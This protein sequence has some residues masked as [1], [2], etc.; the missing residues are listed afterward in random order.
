MKD[1]YDVLVIGAG[2]GGYVA[3]IRAAQLGKSVGVVEKR[4][5][6]GGTCLNIGCIPSKALLDSSE[7]YSRISNESRE[8]GI[9]VSDVSVDLPVMHGR[10]QAVVDRLTGG[11]AALI[12]AR[13]IDVIPGMATLSGNG[14]VEVSFSGA[15]TTIKATH[16]IIAT[17]SE[18][19]ELP[20][21]PFDGKSIVSSTEAL[22][23][24]AVPKELV[25]GGAGAIGLE[26][27]SVW[28]R[29]GSNV[30]VVEIMEEILP[31]WDA[32]LA[33]T[34]RRELK[35]QGFTF[36]LGHKVTGATPGKGRAKTTVAVETNKG[37][38]IDLKA[39]KVL[40]AVGR[41]PYTEGLGMEVAGVK[42]EDGGPRIAV[43][44]RF[45]TSASGIFAIGDVIRGPM[46]AHK[47]EEEGVAVA[48]IIAGG[49]GHV[50]YNAV[51]GVVYTWPEGACVGRTEEHLKAAGVDYRSGSFNFGANGRALAMSSP[52][53][54]VKILADATT[55]R[56]L[57]AHIVGP[58]ASDLI[59]ELVTTIE[60]G[61]SSEDV[62]RIVHAHPT[63]PEAV[64]EAAKGAGDAAK[65]AVNEAATKVKEA[66]E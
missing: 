32:G 7:L 42:L 15:R 17:G 31:G 45:Q 48:E 63:L 14:E 34:M 9:G 1:T 13:K 66:T 43:D 29:L 38:T 50:N 21:L 6:L 37:T 59:S 55:D 5:T 23:F 40:V 41:K 20:F 46:L 25:I 18:P 22:E 47:A 8:H 11:V 62:A 64:K 28:N 2:P 49:S 33:K 44:D 54:F 12:K 26:L 61:G 56:V 16:I 57:G 27:G 30:T 36:L 52:A 10:K 53:G 65:E 60:Y 19:V 39:D 3:A 24:E 58:W 4:D 35:K 51:P